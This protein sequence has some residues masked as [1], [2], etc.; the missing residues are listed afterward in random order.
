M[1]GAKGENSP[2]GGYKVTL[3]H[4]M[5]CSHD[6]VACVLCVVTSTVSSL[7]ELCDRILKGQEV[8]LQSVESVQQAVLRGDIITQV[9]KA[10]GRWR[11]PKHGAEAG[12]TAAQRSAG[13]LAQW[14]LQVL[15]C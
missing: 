7:L 2:P 1:N 3:P 15:V 10:G 13:V 12:C 14:V 6:R 8:D 9:R 11:L 4:I 5:D